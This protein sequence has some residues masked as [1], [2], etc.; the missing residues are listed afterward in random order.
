MLHVNFN[1]LCCPI[2]SEGRDL[3]ALAMQ[4]TSRPT[5]QPTNQPTVVNST[6]NPPPSPHPLNTPHL[7]RPPLLLH[8]IHCVGHCHLIM[9]DPSCVIAEA[10]ERAV[11]FCRPSDAYVQ[12][13]V[14]LDDDSRVVQTPWL[15]WSGSLG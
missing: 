6:S 3:P 12:S 7:T 9:C 2:G 15:K 8:L 4:P 1:S 5:D 11:N 10:S 13:S 14:L